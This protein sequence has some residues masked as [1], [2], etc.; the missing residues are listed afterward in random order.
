MT[1]EKPVVELLQEM[2]RDMSY[3][4]VLAFFMQ[5]SEKSDDP[6]V[7]WLTEFH[8]YKLYNEWKKSME[9]DSTNE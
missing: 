4:E 5:L 6:D 7:K 1:K 9:D 2:V 3:Q 8:Q